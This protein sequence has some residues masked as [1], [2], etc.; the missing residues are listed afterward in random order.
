MSPL[1][2]ML[3]LLVLLIVDLPIHRYDLLHN[4]HLNLEDL[5]ELFKVAQVQMESTPTI[6]RKEKK[7]FYKCHFFLYSFFFLS[8]FFVFVFVFFVF[9]LI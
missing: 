2:S 7:S 4:A 5:D 9:V 6:F 3:T 8:F 1:C